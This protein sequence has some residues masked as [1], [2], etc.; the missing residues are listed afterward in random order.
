[1][2]FLSQ[3]QVVGQRIVEIWKSP[4]DQSHLED[5]N[6]SDMDWFAHRDVVVQLEAG[7]SFSLDQAENLVDGLRGFEGSAEAWERARRFKST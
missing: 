7:D 1:M 4:P 5:P 3:E 6:F 2:V